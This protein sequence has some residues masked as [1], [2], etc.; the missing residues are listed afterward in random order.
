MTLYD[1]RENETQE[2]IFWVTLVCFCLPKER[3]TCVMIGVVISFTNNF[4][5]HETCMIIPGNHT[6]HT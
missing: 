1:Y 4:F 2:F 3:Y 6:N 5:F